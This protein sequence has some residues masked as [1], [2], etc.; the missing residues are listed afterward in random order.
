[1]FSGPFV[2]SWNLDG[3]CLQIFL[4]KQKPRFTILSKQSLKTR[5]SSKIVCNKS[6]NENNNSNN[7]NNN[8]NNNDNNNDDKVAFRGAF[9]IYQI[10]V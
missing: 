8:N 2:E 4:K 1:M 3:K 6:G 7:N 5:F 9:Q 10:N